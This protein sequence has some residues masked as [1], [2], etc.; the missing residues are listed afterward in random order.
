M[1]SALNCKVEEPE[2]TG[3]IYQRVSLVIKKNNKKLAKVVAS[4]A[5]AV[6][7]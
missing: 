5:D 2:E 7:L 1:R 3:G 6:F 4:H